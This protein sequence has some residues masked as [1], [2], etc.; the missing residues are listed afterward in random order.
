MQSA[1]DKNAG[2]MTKKTVA[3]K[4]VPWFTDEIRPQ[5]RTIRRR[6]KI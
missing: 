2:E 3:R 4:E 1:L 5:K 6:E